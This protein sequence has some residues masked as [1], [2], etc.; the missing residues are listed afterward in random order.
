MASTRRLQWQADAIVDAPLGVTWA[1]IDDLSL[2]PRYHPVVR[3]VEL[4]TGVS[5]R[6]PGVEYRCVVPEGPRRGWCVEKVIDHVPLHR[7]TVAFT[8]DSWGLSKLIDDFVTE[9]VVEPSGDSMTRVVLRGFYTP[10]GAWGAVLNT[11]VL[12]RQMRR[13]A[14]DTLR[15]L[16]QLLASGRPVEGSTAR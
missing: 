6:A 16:G 9:I 1:A 4:P 15:G 14:A 11:L 7:T 12:R 3:N 13:R 10:R 8:D 5:R 2:I